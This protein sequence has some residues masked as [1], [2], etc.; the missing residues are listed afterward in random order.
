MVEMVVEDDLESVKSSSSLFH[1]C[2]SPL[3]IFLS[4]FPEKKCSNFHYLLVFTKIPYFANRPDF[5]GNFVQ[6]S[7]CVSWCIFPKGLKIL[8]A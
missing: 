5:I 2:P 6:I 7:F 3:L 4:L 8:S 1:W